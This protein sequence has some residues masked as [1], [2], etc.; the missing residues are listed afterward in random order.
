MVCD[1]LQY[2]CGMQPGERNVVDQ[3]LLELTLWEEHKI[4]VFR[5]S[6]AEVRAFGAF[7]VSFVWVLCVCV[8][9]CV[10]S[11][12]FVCACV[13]VCVLCVFMCFACVCFVRVPFGGL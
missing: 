2:L 6:L 10:C 9:F 7:S 3:R 1:K 5:L 12:S 11:L 13:C 4:Q 8:C